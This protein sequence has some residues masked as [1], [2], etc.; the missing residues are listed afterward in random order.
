MV[1]AAVA[2]VMSLPLAV[3]AVSA[4]VVVSTVGDGVEI[5]PC[6]VEVDCTIARHAQTMHPSTNDV[7]KTSVSGSQRHCTN[8]GHLTKVVVVLL[9]NG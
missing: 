1:L 9:K 8:V 2:V 3:V 6:F 4:V 7:A 5:V